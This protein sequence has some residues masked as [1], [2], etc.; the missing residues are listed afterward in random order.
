MEVNLQIFKAVSNAYEWVDGQAAGVGQCCRACGDCCDFER[1]GHRLYVTTPE[2]IY[3]KHFSDAAIQGMTAGVC[4]Y[5][6]DGQCSVYPYRF[7]G[8][9]IFKCKGDEEKQNA[10]SEQTIR[11]FKT[12]CSECGI[13]Y[14]Y[15]YLKAGLEMLCQGEIK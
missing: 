15:V 8:C 4:P 2:L 12:L 9:R 7:S 5:R 14:H 1:F 10:L 3:F 6:I 13:P 11:K